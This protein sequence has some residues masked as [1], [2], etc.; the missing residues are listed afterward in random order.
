MSSFL[1]AD[2]PV[3]IHLANMGSPKSLNTDDDDKRIYNSALDC[4]TLFENLLTQ[5]AQNNGQHYATLRD[6]HLRFEHW[7]EFVG[8]LATEQASLDHRLKPYTEVRDLVLQMLQML[9]SN[10]RHGRW[11]SAECGRAL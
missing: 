9:D 8:A 5:F 4:G 6:H 10:L 3:S 7:Q 1:S 2:L 11:L